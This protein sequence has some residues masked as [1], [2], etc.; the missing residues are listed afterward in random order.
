MATATAPAR[1]TDTSTV[2]QER[3]WTLGSV[4]SIGFIRVKPGH[5]LAYGRELAAT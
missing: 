1:A 5:T 3:P 4:W 2:D